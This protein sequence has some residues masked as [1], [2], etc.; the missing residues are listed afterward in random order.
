M[1]EPIFSEGSFV[2]SSGEAFWGHG[3]SKSSKSSQPKLGWAG[4]VGREQ[5]QVALLKDRV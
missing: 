2:Q 3:S 1:N 5:A 4:T